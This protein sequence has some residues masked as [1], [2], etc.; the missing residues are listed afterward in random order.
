[1]RMDTL[2]C[3]FVDPLPTA[4][5]VRVHL[6]KLL[7]VTLQ[8]YQFITILSIQTIDGLRGNGRSSLHLA[9]RARTVGVVAS[10]APGRGR[11]VVSSRDPGT[12]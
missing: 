3:Y 6:L 10:N 8:Y 7:I 11:P 1:M 9:N 12:R 4:Q 2:Y 5:L